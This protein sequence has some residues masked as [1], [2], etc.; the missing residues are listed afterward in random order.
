MTFT[1]RPLQEML[2]A[3]DTIARLKPQA[4]NSIRS[5]R[6]QLGMT[7]SEFA[8]EV[9]ST[10]AYVSMVENGSRTP[11]AEMI[12]ATIA[13]LQ[14]QLARVEGRSHGDQGKAR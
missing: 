12:R 7:Q 4:A 9:G 11:S 5:A 8:R 2:E 14:Q 13:L 1:P 10:Q 6:D 3:Q